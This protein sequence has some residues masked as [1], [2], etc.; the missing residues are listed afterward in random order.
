MSGPAALNVVAAGVVSG[1]ATRPLTRADA[2]KPESSVVE[3]IPG[4]SRQCRQPPA[5]AQDR[6]AI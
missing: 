6:P 1:R 5:R 4:E 2:V 3:I